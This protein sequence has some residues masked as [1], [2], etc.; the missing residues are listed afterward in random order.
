MGQYKISIYFQ[1]QFGILLSLVKGLE[2]QLNLPFI[3]IVYGL[4]ADAK[5]F[6][7]EPIRRRGKNESIR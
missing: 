4:T 2:I 5:G 1:I 3:Q 7:I 6:Y